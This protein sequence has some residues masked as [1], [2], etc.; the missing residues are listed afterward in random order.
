VAEPE[1]TRLFNQMAAA[2]P[3]FAAYQRNTTRIIPVIG[4]TRLK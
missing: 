3:N 1:R 2:R 4:L